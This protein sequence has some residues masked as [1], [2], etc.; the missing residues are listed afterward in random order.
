MAYG[1]LT[2]TEYTYDAAK[3]VTS[4][5]HRRFMGM[6]YET[7]LKLVYAYQNNDLVARIDEY[8][9]VGLLA[10]VVFEYD[11]R[12]RLISEV[13]TGQNPYDLNLYLPPVANSL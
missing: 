3:R 12:G 6:Q 11:T 13:R 8:N 7:M 4:I 1:N 5:D 10:S 2:R 9:G